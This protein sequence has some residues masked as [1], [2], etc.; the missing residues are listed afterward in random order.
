[1]QYAAKIKSGTAQGFL[2]GDRVKH[3]KS[4]KIY[5]VISSSV[6]LEGEARVVRLDDCKRRIVWV[7]ACNLELLNR[8]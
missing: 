3:V 5:E 4:K 8:D 1:M 6:S 7:R 2:F